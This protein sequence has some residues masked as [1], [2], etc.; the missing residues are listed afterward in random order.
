[1][2]NSAN[3]NVRLRAAA[4]VFKNKK[5][6][7]VKQHNNQYF[8]FPGGGIEKN[9][10]IEN[11]LKREVM[12]EI[13]STVKSTSFYGAFISEVDKTGIRHCTLAFLTELN[14][15]PPMNPKGEIIELTWCSLQKPFKLKLSNSTAF[16]VDKLCP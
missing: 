3:S 5:L 15:K 14:H 10:S 12:E 9:E 8:Q 6:L 4:L 1:M 7:L 16:F 13:S 11:C 2:K